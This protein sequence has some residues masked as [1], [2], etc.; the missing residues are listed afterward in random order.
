[1]AVLRMDHVAVVVD[2][3][4]AAIEFFL[5]LG[6]EL[7]GE[8]SL[9]G[10]VVDRI[11]G[12]EGVRTDNAFM[13]TPDGHAQLEL[14]KFHSPSIEADAPPAPPNAPGLRHLTFAVDDIDDVVER[15]Q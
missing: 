14:T 6:L 12:L 7:Q 5:E 2:D 9:E 13:R 15:L 8:A 3:L 1:M 4:P 10:R 11:L